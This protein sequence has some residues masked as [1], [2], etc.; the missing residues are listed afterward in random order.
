VLFSPITASALVVLSIDL[1]VRKEGYDIHPDG[2]SPVP[3]AG[4][5]PDRKGGHSLA[6]KDGDSPPPPVGGHRKDLRNGLRIPPTR[7]GTR[8]TL[9]HPSRLTQVRQRLRRQLVSLRATR[10]RLFC[11]RPHLVRSHPLRAGS[12]RDSLSLPNHLHCSK[13]PLQ[14]LRRSKGIRPERKTHRAQTDNHD[15]DGICRG[16]PFG[17]SGCKRTTRP[18]WV[19]RLCS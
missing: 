5:L 16:A 1:R 13:D 4:D 9:K 11:P 17:H 12:L 18:E 15:P 14:L 10:L 2:A 6:L 8:G 7:R 3:K 19:R